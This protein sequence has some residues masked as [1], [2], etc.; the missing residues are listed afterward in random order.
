M[1]L[2]RVNGTDH[3]V[4]VTADWQVVNNLSANHTFFVDQ[5]R[6]TQG[7]ACF[8]VLDAVSFLNFTLN[9]SNHCVFHFPDA[10]IFDWGFTP[11]VVD[12]F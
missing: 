5:E 12:K 3:F 8:W 7:N 1:E 4:D 6:T 2:Q 9:V 11:C 10:A